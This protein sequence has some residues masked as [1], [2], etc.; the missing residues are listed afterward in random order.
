MLPLHAERSQLI[1]KVIKV[2]A[3]T[4]SVRA[5]PDPK[6]W[7]TSSPFQ[8]LRKLLAVSFNT[9]KNP[10]TS[11]PHESLDKFVYFRYIFLSGGPQDKVRNSGDL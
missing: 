3:R 6:L 1:I 5:E 2:S 4:L 11:K 9:S 8:L 7:L 10:Q